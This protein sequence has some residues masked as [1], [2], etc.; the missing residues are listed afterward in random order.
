M[1]ARVSQGK[2]FVSV[3]WRS[4][5]H[6]NFVH[7]RLLKIPSQRFISFE[8]FVKKKKKYKHSHSR[9]MKLT[10]VT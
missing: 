7:F 5:I 10:E 2:Y 4:S 1:G 6:I 8:F 3:N 9:L